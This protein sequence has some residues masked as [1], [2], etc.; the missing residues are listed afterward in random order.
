[1]K[2]MEQGRCQRVREPTAFGR[3]DDERGGHSFVDQTPYCLCNANHGP[4]GQLNDAY[5]PNLCDLRADR[6]RQ[7]IPRV[8]DRNQAYCSWIGLALE[9]GCVYASRHLHVQSPA[10]PCEPPQLAV[11]VSPADRTPS[12]HRVMRWIEAP[13][14][15]V[16]WPLLLW[17]CGR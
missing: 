13:L 1:M 8:F 7:S 12:S 16:G 17:L 3:P 9:F 5:R 10:P 14:A 2:G 11:A 4:D 15:T 6:R